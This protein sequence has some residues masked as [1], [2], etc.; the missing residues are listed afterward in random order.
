VEVY[1]HALLTQALDGSMWSASR[2]G[3]FT[4]TER[5]SGTHCIGGWGVRNS[6]TLTEPHIKT[7]KNRLTK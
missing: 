7:K 3:S 1:I 4:P 2:P 6:Y 5:A